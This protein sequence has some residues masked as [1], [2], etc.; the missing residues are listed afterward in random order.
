MITKAD[1]SLIDND[2]IQKYKVVNSISLKVMLT[3]YVKSV[4]FM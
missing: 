1:N 4:T 2:I 3:F